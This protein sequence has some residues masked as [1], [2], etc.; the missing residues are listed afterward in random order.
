MP[1][2]NRRLQDSVEVNGSINGWNQ[3]YDDDMTCDLTWDDLTWPDMTWP[4]MTSCDLTWPGMI[5]W[6]ENAWKL[7]S[8]GKP[9]NAGLPGRMAIELELY[10]CFVQVQ[11]WQHQEIWELWVFFGIFVNFSCFYIVSA[12]FD[13]KRLFTVKIQDI[14]LGLL[15]HMLKWFHHCRHCQ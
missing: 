2:T 14:L 9:A 3:L 4:D 11:T 5:T 8:V 10:V 15:P 1:L 7:A 6:P 13:T 12:V